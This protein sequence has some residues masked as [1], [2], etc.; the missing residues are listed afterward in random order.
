MRQQP[1]F[2][3]LLVGALLGIVLGISVVALDWTSTWP[4]YGTSVVVALVVAA[5]T[6]PF[7]FG[8]LKRVRSDMPESEKIRS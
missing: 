2:I 1:F 4:I 8:S 7:V 3:V 6:M 5:S